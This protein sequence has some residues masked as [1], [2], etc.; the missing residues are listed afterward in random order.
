MWQNKDLQIHRMAL[1]NGACEFRAYFSLCAQWE[2]YLVAFGFLVK[3][4]DKRW[5]T[6]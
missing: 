2:V 6:N 5:L 3:T 4:G 1:A